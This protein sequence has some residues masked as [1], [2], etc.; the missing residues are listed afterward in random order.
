MWCLHCIEIYSGVVLNSPVAH[1]MMS[2]PHPH[3]SNACVDRG[4]YI[5]V[6]T[7]LADL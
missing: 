1:T 6:M 3:A 4:I 7:N 5:G 2:T